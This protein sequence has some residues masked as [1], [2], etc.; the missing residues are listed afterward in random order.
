MKQPFSPI[1][2]GEVIDHLGPTLVSVLGAA[3]RTRQVTGAE[4]SDPT[5]DPDHMRDTVILAPAAAE[6]DGILGLAETAARANAAALAVKC[7]DEEVDALTRRAEHTR[8]TILRVASHA[9][10]RLF[11]AALAQTFTSDRNKSAPPHARGPEPLFA[12]ANELAGEFG[13]SCAIEDLGRRIVAYSAVPGQLI[14]PLR[15]QGILTRKVPDSPQ[16]DEDYREVLR[17]DRPLVYA[18]QGDDEARIAIRILVGTLPLGTI[19]VLSPD[20][21]PQLTPAQERSLR[22]AAAVA[23]GHLLD[24]VRMR[25]DVQRPREQRLRTML[26]GTDVSGSEFAELGIPEPGGAALAVFDPGAGNDRVSLTQLRSTVQRHLA[27]HHPECVVLERGGRV[28]AL[29]SHHPAVPVSELITPLLP[30][31]D[32]LVSPGTRVALPGV[33]ERPAAIAP[34]RLLAEQ[35]LRTARGGTYTDRILTLERFRTALTLDRIGEVLHTAPELVNPELDTLRQAEPALATTVLAWCAALGNVART[36]RALGVHENTVRH[37]MRQV[38]ERYGV[39]LSSD[40]DILGAW[41]QLRAL[42]GPLER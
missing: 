12:L 17:S 37:R 39:P 3:D 9:S 28:H 11:D 34:L 14:D 4:F 31:L 6:A 35:L 23:A 18:R 33:A 19:W 15:A 2:L 7:A 13:G 38:E 41:L 27:L 36:A 8:L 10:W 1:T 5:M 16:N 24:D 29:I 40:D 20:A 30:L 25:A 32:R 21:D 22:S 42:P 26:D